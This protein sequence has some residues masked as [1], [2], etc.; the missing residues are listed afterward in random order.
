MKYLV[1]S[2]KGILQFTSWK[3]INIADSENENPAAQSKIST[4]IL[5]T[6]IKKLEAGFTICPS[7]KDQ[8]SGN[9]NSDKI[10]KAKILNW[11]FQSGFSERSPF[12]SN[13][14]IPKFLQ[15]IYI[16]IKKISVLNLR[17]NPKGNKVAGPDLIK[18]LVLK[19][20]INEIAGVVTAIFQKYLSSGTLPFDLR[21][22]CLLRYQFSRRLKLPSGRSYYDGNLV[23]NLRQNQQEQCHLYLSRKINMFTT[24]Q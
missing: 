4:K 22:S 18:P 2:K 20:L 3:H 24:C 6:L 13:S 1:K 21:H 14:H 12:N 9:L 5:Y 16:T 7:L 15:M 17:D 8:V 10:D 19:E 23:M 11:Q